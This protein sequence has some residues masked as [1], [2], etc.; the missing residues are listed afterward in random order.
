MAK[1]EQVG[2][3]VR[4]AGLGGYGIDEPL[5]RPF[6]IVLTPSG[7]FWYGWEVPKTEGV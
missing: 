4:A 6:A 3:L 1:T 7:S 5:G 2:D